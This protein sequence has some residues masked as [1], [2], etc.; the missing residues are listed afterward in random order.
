MRSI[1]MI[2]AGL[3]AVVILSLALPCWAG[4]RKIKMTTEIPPGIAIPDKM[5]TRLGTVNFF[6]GFPYDATVEKI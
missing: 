4:P 5:E 6:D 2:K 1:R 3:V